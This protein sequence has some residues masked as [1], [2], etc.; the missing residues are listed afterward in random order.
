M[1]NNGL[2]LAQA[3]KQHL[4]QL[5]AETDRLRPAEDAAVALAESFG[6]FEA[7]YAAIRRHVGI[8]HLPQTG[9]IQLQGEDVKPFLHNMLSQDINAMTGGQTRRA[10]LLDAEG[11]M[12]SPTRMCTSATQATWL[13]LDRFDVRGDDADARQPTVR[14]RCHGSTIISERS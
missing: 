5:G 1:E 6:S 10:F 11:H 9:V 13:E 14:R 12:S 8:L 4:E 3:C 2:H 7:E